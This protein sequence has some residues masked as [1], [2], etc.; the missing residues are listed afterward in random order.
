MAGTSSQL[1][2]YLKGESGEDVL[3]YIKTER[4]VC[5]RPSA[6]TSQASSARPPLTARRSPPDG[7]VDLTV[8][9]TSFWNTGRAETQ[10]CGT[11]E[12]VAGSARACSAGA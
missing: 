3:E 7:D 8:L 6:S 4:S 5:A 2:E 12:R 9:E 11:D 10:R 1:P